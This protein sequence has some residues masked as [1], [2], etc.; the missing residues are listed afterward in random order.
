MKNALAITAVVLATIGVASSGFAATYSKGAGG[1]FQ[2]IE[3]SVVSLNQGNKTIILKDK[4]DGKDYV[5]GLF[6]A[7]FATVG[8]G[9]GVKVALAQGSN[10]ARNIK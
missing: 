10:L 3:G 7:D 2:T 4:D 9:Q 8:Q 1:S 6:A 5:V